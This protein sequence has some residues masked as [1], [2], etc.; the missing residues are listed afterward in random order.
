MA[1]RNLFLLATVAAA[2]LFFSGCATTAVSSLKTVQDEFNAINRDDGI[3]YA[4]M[5]YAQAEVHVYMA[6]EECAEEGWLD[7][8]ECEEYQGIARARMDTVRRK[9]AEG[10]RPAKAETPPPAPKPAPAP[11]P[12]PAPAPVAP[13]S[14]A[15]VVAPAPVE[16]VA[17]AKEEMRS[18]VHFGFDRSHIGKDAAQ[19]LKAVTEYLKSNPGAR[20]KVEGHTCSIGTNE[21][22][23]GLSDRRANS[24]KK[25]LIKKTKISPDNIETVGYGEEKPAKPNNTKKGRQYNR[26]AEI[27]ITK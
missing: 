5:E 26:R 24:V 14:A 27:V 19:K 20:V 23:L 2:S 6:N 7:L 16:A 21:Y 10:K 13:P 12:A 22:N 11:E 15:P 17:P 4:P 8:R 1:K 9:I 3:K 25:Y 18:I